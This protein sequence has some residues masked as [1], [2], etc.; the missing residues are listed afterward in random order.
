MPELPEAVVIARQMDETVRDKRIESVDILQPKILNRSGKT[1][2]QI[3]SGLS[4]E[5][6]YPFGKW[7]GI[8]L[9]NDHRLMISLGM[10][11]EIIYFEKGES[12]PDKIRFILHFSDQSGFYITLWWFGYVHLILPGENH[13]M[14]DSLGPDPLEM[15]RNA[16]HQILSNRKG[17]IKAFLLNQKRIRGIGNFYIQE[18]LFQAKLHPLRTIPSLSQNDIDTL[19]NAIQS[20]FIESIRLDSSWYEQ[21]FFGKRGGYTLENMSFTFQENDR[22]PV[23]THPIE[24]I[25]TGST[26]QYICARCQ[27]L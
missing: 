1:V 8:Q 3:L 12:L 7:I 27:K 19:F 20:V 24:K 26:S 4:I 17:G 13:D 25:K 10:G 15:D 9:S 18:I 21:D 2:K 14:T 16:F 5:K 11:G 23:C 6:V 22:C